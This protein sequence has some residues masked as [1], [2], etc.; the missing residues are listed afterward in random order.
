M[1][2]AGSALLFGVRTPT[3]ALIAIALAAAGL[4]GCG[5]SKPKILDT[6]RIERAI[7][8]SVLEKRRLQTQVSCPSG[9]ERKKGLVFRCVATY[10]GGR[11]PFEVKQDDDKGSVHYRGL[12]K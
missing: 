4:T 11:T 6:E 12:K 2:S 8:R 5:D 9:I 7:E 10:K 3:V 1:R